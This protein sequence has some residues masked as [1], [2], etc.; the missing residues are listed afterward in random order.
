[1][2]LE[3]HWAPVLARGPASELRSDS[4]VAA[5]VSDYHSEPVLVRGSAS[6]YQSVWGPAMELVSAL[7]SE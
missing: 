3:S 4:V 2:N 6:D 1:M 5:S 7:Q